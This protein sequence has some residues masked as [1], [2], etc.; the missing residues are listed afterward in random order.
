MEIRLQVPALTSWLS[1]LVWTCDAS[2]KMLI[3]ST[4]LRRSLR[5][6]LKMAAIPVYPRAI[7]SLHH[8]N[9][10]FPAEYAHLGFNEDII[11][12]APIEHGNLKHARGLASALKGYIGGIP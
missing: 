6:S 3:T 12:G 7:N 10:N 4:K 1:E 2:H 11:G 8:T 9:P 5:Q